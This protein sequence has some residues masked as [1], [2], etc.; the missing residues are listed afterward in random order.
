MI[1]TCL[2]DRVRRSVFFAYVL[3]IATLTHWPGLVVTGPTARPDLLVH[4]GVFSLWTLLAWASGLLG[5]LGDGR[6]A[7]RSMAVAAVYAALDE[8]TQQFVGR[9]SSWEDFAANLMG[10]GLAG[11]A[12]AGLGAAIHR[13]TSPGV[14][15]PDAFSAGPG[16][17]RL[18][19][20][21]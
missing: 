18:L 2:I 3:T 7:A 12:I 6:T 21:R 13:L 9:I 11:C 17:A 19:T 8:G 20:R 5:R 16:Q 15:S 1:G 4:I 14:R 10:V